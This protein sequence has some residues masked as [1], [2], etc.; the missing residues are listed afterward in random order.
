[1]L[2]IGK[3]YSGDWVLRDVSLQLQPGELVVFE[4]ANGSGKSS[5]L[6]M[7]AGLTRASAGVIEG[8]PATASYAPDRLPPDERMSAR[9]L[10]RHLGRVRGMGRVEARR[11]ADTLVERFELVGDPGAAMRTLSMG[12]VQKVCLAQAFLMPTELLVLDEPT[13]SLDE[14]ATSTLSAL[15]EER[16]SDGATC[17]ISDH[18]DRRS[19]HDGAIV[20][21]VAAGSVI[22]RGS[23]VEPTRIATLRRDP[24]ATDIA[25]QSLPGVRNVI[26]D[27]TGEVEIEMASDHSNRVVDVAIRSGWTLTEMRTP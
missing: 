10:L 5:L 17:V 12:N 18:P 1:M 19:R 23:A 4:G 11:A 20:F 25:W 15:I 13:S 2:G 3:R 9:T 6:R 16:R 22:R 8:R 26:E 14:A 7:I 24:N 27:G 21:E